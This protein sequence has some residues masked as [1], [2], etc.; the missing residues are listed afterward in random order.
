M[1]RR[2]SKPAS[3]HETVPGQDSSQESVTETAASSFVPS[4]ISEQHIISS[5]SSLTG[6]QSTVDNS[7]SETTKPDVNAGF[8]AD[9][10]ESRDGI[11]RP[12]ATLS[13]KGVV[14][15]SVRSTDDL[16]RSVAQLSPSRLQLGF[17]ANRRSAPF[18][19]H[20]DQV[21][22]EAPLAL[23]PDSQLSSQ[24]PSL[25]QPLKRR[26]SLVKL[27]LSLEG[28]AEV[29]T[30]TGNTP[31][32]PRPQSVLSNKQ[33]P[34][35]MHGLQRSHSAI[36]RVRESKVNPLP[37]SFPRRSMIGRSRDARTWEFYCDSDARNALTEQAER[38]EKGSATAAIGLIRSQSN[39]SKTMTPNTNKRNA[40]SQKPETAK[41]RKADNLKSCKPVLE[42]AVSSVAR[43]QTTTNDVSKAV[44]LGSKHRKSNSQSALF[45]DGDSDKE[46]WIPGT[47]A[48]QPRRRRPM[49]SP[50]TTRILEESLYAPSQSTGTG[51]L[52]SRASSSI[53]HE[54]PETAGK[55][56]QENCSYQVD[57]EVAT[58]MGEATPREEEDLDCVQ[59]L[60]SLSQAA[61]Q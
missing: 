1:T 32:P 5:Q 29:T 55:A 61:W 28:K 51:N 48:S 59:N 43:L 57:D 12:I 18:V 60:L 25:M 38:E 50:A 23:S 7:S 58:F 41:R 30:R 24:S 40:H 16:I 9:T 10:Q 37:L 15:E 19:I 2:K 21:L 11:A 52:L 53:T 46:N 14:G 31:S 33:T 20:D 26:S 35:A 56:G 42:R 49:I 27:S 39:K 34:R 4:G 6:S 3:Q 8:M 17:L 44:K 36:E 54:P 47:Q 22:A 45:E 13:G